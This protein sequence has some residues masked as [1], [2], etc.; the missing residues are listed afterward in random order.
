MGSVVAVVHSHRE[1]TD[2]SRSFSEQ[3][4]ERWPPVPGRACEVKGTEPDS[5][6]PQKHPGHVASDPHHT[7]SPRDTPLELEL[8][9][10]VVGSYQNRSVRVCEAHERKERLKKE[11]HVET[12]DESRNQNIFPKKAAAGEIQ[13]FPASSVSGFS[14][15][16]FDSSQRTNEYEGVGTYFNTNYCLRT[17]SILVLPFHHIERE[18]YTVQ[19]LSPPSSQFSWPKCA[20]IDPKSSTAGGCQVGG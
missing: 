10:G 16:C 20:P 17:V 4:S 6:T 11:F 5:T 12:N 13:R 1:Q 19:S 3:A 18:R 14:C 7:P 8:E 2:C 15:D 9:S